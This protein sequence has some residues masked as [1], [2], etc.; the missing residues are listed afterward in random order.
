MRSPRILAVIL[1]GGQ[2]SR[3]GPLTDEI[4]KP[5]L[6]LGGTCRLI[7]VA[8]S[9]LVN[10]GI[11]DVWI[12]EQHL[13]H[14]LN[15]HLASGRPWDL[16]RGHGGLQLLAPF[17]G[18][19]GE[20]FAHGNSDSLWRHRER[21]RQAQ[22]DLVIILSADHLYSLDMRDVV[23]T[24]RDSQAQLTIVTTQTQNDPSSHAVVH[25][26]ANGE[27]TGLD[28]KPEDPDHNLVAAE[29]FC[30][31]TAVLLDALDHLHAELGELEDYGHDLLP[32]LIEQ[33]RAVEHRLQG[34]WRDLGTIQAYWQVHQ[35]LLDGHVEALDHPG[36][37]IRSAQPQ[38]LPARVTGS[39]VVHDSLVSPGA[40]VSGTV[41]DSVIGPR[42]RVDEGAE[43]IASVL[44][45][46]VHVP[47]GARLDHCIVMAD[48]EID[49]VVQ[50]GPTSD[51][52]ITVISPNGQQHRSE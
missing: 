41:R 50:V 45:D 31:G 42:C 38:L 24:H 37:P 6:R 36:W 39:A 27:V 7:D 3:L 10:S 33:H 15:E 20:G 4:A 44:L 5:A 51:G 30:V 2:G 34:Y 22:P 29:I 40:T 28:Y 1:A 11:D 48:T 12:I 14:T 49:A 32:H 46:G 23:A 25:T 35:D 19:P 13:P 8:L 9:N 16:D 21:I 18:G 43:V 52:R 47:A 26:T 17:T